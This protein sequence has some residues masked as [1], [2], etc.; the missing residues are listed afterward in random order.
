VVFKPFGKAPAHRLLRAVEVMLKVARKPAFLKIEKRVELLG[1]YVEI[2]HVLR[3][4]IDSNL[5]M[6]VAQIGA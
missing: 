1:E 5:G 6:P 3:T 2:F 4:A